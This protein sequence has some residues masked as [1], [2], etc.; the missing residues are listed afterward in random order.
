MDSLSFQIRTTYPGPLDF[1]SKALQPGAS[2]V[3]RLLPGGGQ[4]AGDLSGFSLADNGRST[5]LATL[6]F[7][8]TEGQMAR[9]A[10]PMLRFAC[11][12]HPESF[13]DSF[14]SFLLGHGSNFF[15]LRFF[16]PVR[17]DATGTF[18]LDVEGVHRQADHSIRFSRKTK[19]VSILVQSECG[20]CRT[21]CEIAILSET[22]CW[23]DHPSQRQAFPVLKS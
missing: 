9:S 6:F 19:G 20:S 21:K 15:L 4:S 2:S 8:Q 7:G 16:R 3:K 17:A 14:V 11:R 1:K 13:F 18:R 10:V 5:K 12:R 23:K 22:T